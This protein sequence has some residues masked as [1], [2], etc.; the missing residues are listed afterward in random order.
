MVAQARAKLQEVEVQALD[1][2]RLESLI[3]GQ[4]MAR[5]EEVADAARAALAGHAVLNVNSTATGGGVAE[6]LQTLLAYVRGAGVDARWLVID[7]DPRFFAITKRL[8]NG[9]Y[10]SPGD[11]GPLERAERRHYERV[12]RGNAKELLAL[13]RDGDVVIIHD[14]QPAGLIDAITRAG[15]RVVWRCHVGCDEANEWTRRAWDFLQPYL[16][17]ADAYA[18]SRPAFA[19]PW[20]G[21]ARTHVIPPSID[22]FSAKNEPMSHRNASLALGYVG[23]LDGDGSPPVVPFSRRDGSPGRINRH[24]DILQSGPPPPREAPLV[25]QASRWDAMKD[26]AGVMEGFANHVDPALGA[27]LVLAGPAVTGVAD[28]PE[29]AEVYAACVD[30]WRRLPHAIRGRVHLACVPMADPDEAA[31]IVNALQRHASVVV[32]KSLAEGFGLTVTEAMWKSRPIVASAV[33]GIRDQ[34]TDREHGL[35]IE[36]PRDLRAFG[37]CVEELL[38]DPGQAER[39]GANAH[40]RASAEFLGDRHLEQY[41]RLLAGI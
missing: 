25:V 11:G 40:A 16:E 20:A 30:H 32:Q 17:D 22:P 41:G 35:L 27:H 8:H 2:A 5:Y 24:V 15:A 10:G 23:L 18:V 6:M 19:P 12:L 4:R 1:A 31:A 36:D 39:L 38:R 13:V 28:D 14:P 29:A 26:M 34:L 33:G 3:G 9:L 7:G 21:P 37:R